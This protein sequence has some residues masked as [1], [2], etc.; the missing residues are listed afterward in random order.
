MRSTGVRAGVMDAILKTPL[1]NE[2]IREL[3][4]FL[5]SD[6]T[7]DES[8]DIVTLDGFPTALAIGPEAGTAQRMAAA[9]LGWRERTCLRVFG[10]SRAHSGHIDAPA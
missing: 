6:A 9:H 7:S 5:I 1:S 3:D 2:E 10:T 8:M 4:V